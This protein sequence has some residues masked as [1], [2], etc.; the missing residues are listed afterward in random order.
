M[1]VGSHA[2]CPW[3]FCPRSTASNDVAFDAWRASNHVQALAT[4]FGRAT[5]D[6][7]L[8]FDENESDTKF[9]HLT[10]AIEF[11]LDHNLL[12][13][14]PSVKNMRRLR[15]LGLDSNKITRIEPGDTWQSFAHREQSWLLHMSL[16]SN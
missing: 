8:A 9:D 15:W 7:G 4:F 1:Y 11:G 5:V 13:R 6:G 10:G 12:T 14:V 16:K 3:L 2:A